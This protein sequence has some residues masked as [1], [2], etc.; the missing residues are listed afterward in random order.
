M[1]TCKKK[2]KHLNKKQSLG[3]D[4]LKGMSKQPGNN[5]RL[6]EAL[7]RIVAR[8]KE[9][10]NH[11]DNNLCIEM[12]PP[13]SALLFF[14]KVMI[15]QVGICENG[16]QHLAFCGQSDPADIAAV[17]SALHDFDLFVFEL[18]FKYEKSEDGSS[19]VIYCADEDIYDEY[20]KAVASTNQSRRSKSDRHNE[21][22]SS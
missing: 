12:R 7:D 2:K 19:G 15:C 18:P 8:L 22:T 13:R 21:I 6:D 10:L 1:R 9:K 5:T 3:V 14:G 17:S 20:V 4:G 11:P 16:C